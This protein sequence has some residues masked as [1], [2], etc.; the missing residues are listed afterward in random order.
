LRELASAGW[1]VA[2]VIV[3]GASGGNLPHP[4]EVTAATRERLAPAYLPVYV[5]TSQQ[6]DCQQWGAAVRGKT[7]SRITGLLQSP[8][9][10]ELLSAIHAL[11]K[12][13]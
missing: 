1:F 5:R 6:T 10:V 13:R 4:G 12:H 2:R 3:R 9:K 7:V 11:R 8:P